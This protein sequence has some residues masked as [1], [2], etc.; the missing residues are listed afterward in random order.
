VPQA[1]SGSQSPPPPRPPGQAIPQVPSGIRSIDLQTGELKTVI[2]TP[3]TMGHVQANPWV[4]GE[5]LYCQETGGD[6]PQR[7]WFVRA[8]G[9][10]NQP[11]YKETTDE[12]VTH[13]I[14]LDKD[15]VLFN[16]LGHQPKL[17]TK[18]QGI[19]SIN[20]RNQEVR[21]HGQAE[22]RG[23]WHC[24][25]TADRRW[26]VGDTFT[27]EF[28]VI[29]LL[30][31]ENKLLSAGHRPQGNETHSHHTMSPDGKRV[32]FNSGLLGNRDI[33][34]ITLPEAGNRP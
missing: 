34:T 16:V 13:E 32:L 28:Y 8:D 2:D 9:S 10:G 30:T 29:N 4:S 26:A 24:A 3:F 31:G 12:W 7:M 21:L 33:M 1:P 17:R 19:L 14:W 25:G 23:Y 15:Y 18:P 11:L 20:V 27:G 5:I 22:A 6:A